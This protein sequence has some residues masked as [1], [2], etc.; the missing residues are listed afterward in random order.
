MNTLELQPQVNGVALARADEALHAETLRQRAC[1]ELLRQAAIEAGLLAADDR[2]PAD[3]AMSEAASSAIEALLERELQ[4]PTPSDEACRRYHAAHAARYAVGER[5][6][7]RH[8]LFAVTPGVDV[9]ALRKRAEGCLVEVRC[10]SDR[11]APLTKHRNCFRFHIH[12]KN[13]MGTEICQQHIATGIKLNGIG[14]TSL[15]SVTKSST[16]PLGFTAP[17]V[18]SFW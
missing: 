13:V 16:S 6:L 5:V 15:G 2:L 7:A 14:Y 17:I 3:G 18:P 4:L 12:F 10:K 9:N 11:F 8:I 1:S